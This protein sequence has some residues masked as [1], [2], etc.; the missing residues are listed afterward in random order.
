MAQR[1]GAGMKLISMCVFGDDVLYVGG[2][3]ENADLV[4]QIYPGWT[5]R[6]YVEAAH[7][8]IP[9]LLQRGAEVVEVEV[10]TGNSELQYWHTMTRFGAAADPA[11]EC[12]VFRDA[13]SR[14]NVREAAAVAEWYQSG[15]ALH[16]MRDSQYHDA[17][18]LAGMWGVRGGRLAQIGEWLAPWR[19]HA[20]QRCV[21][22]WFLA[23]LVYPAF[24]ETERL[25]HSTCPAF[26]GR[27]F[28]SHPRYDG[29]VGQIMPVSDGTVQLIREAKQRRRPRRRPHVRAAVLDAEMLLYEPTRKTAIRL[30]ESGATIWHLCDGSRSLAEMIALLGDA[31]PETTVG[32]EV[33]ATVL[34]LASV[35]VVDLV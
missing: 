26:P 2:A 31:Y 1:Q 11:A 24:P 12:I 15:R 9:L 5:L 28:P 27:P 4:H 13:D 17:P 16:V 34:R 32:A 29:F 30:N 33:E 21:D 3:V 19:V 23:S 10:T 7:P 25:E 22:Q 14:L 6:V 35:G 20:G 18:M 8:V